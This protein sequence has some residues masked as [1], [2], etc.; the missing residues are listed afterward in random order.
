MYAS[1]LDTITSVMRSAQRDGSLTRKQDIVPNQKNTNV[2]LIDTAC[3]SRPKFR[4]WCSI[5]SWAHV[6]PGLQIWFI[7]TSPRISDF[8]GFP[9][10]LLQKYP[11]LNIVGADVEKMVEDTPLKQLFDSKKWMQ[12]NIQPVHKTINYRSVMLKCKKA[13]AVSFPKAIF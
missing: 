9:S 2:F 4:V 12:N 6:N 5:E 3:N 1:K 11:N 8:E 10:K 7:M 13:K